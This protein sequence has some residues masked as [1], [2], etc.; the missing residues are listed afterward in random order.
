[1]PLPLRHSR[2]RFHL[3][4][5]G[6]VVLGDVAAGMI[7]GALGGAL[8]AQACTTGAPTCGGCPLTASCTYAA[9]FEPAPAPHLHAGFAD[10]PRPYVL[11]LERPLPAVVR[12]G[13]TFAFDLVLVES[14]SSALAAL[15]GAVRRLEATGL[16][17]ART[18]ERG[19]RS[20]RI[21]LASVEALHG[22]APEVVWRPG[23]RLPQ[24]GPA[25]AW[26]GGA[27]CPAAEALRL[28]FTSP[29]RLKVGG[30]PC[31]APSLVDL[32]RALARRVT[33]F[34]RLHG[35]FDDAL[36]QQLHAAIDL[37]RGLDVHEA[38]FTPAVRE[39]YS[40]RQGRRIPLEGVLGRLVVG[41]GWEPLWPLLDA[42]RLLHVG[43]NATHGLG[44]YRLEAA[45]LPASIPS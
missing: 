42:G 14:A 40:A 9:L 16:G 26:L 3:R 2:Y 7:R 5:E 23:R 4:A 34:A 24:P 27:P 1:M 15:V 8:R 30:R 21:R 45:A 33:A 36:Q 44:A 38:R 18:V 13:R 41:A 32:V 12:P 17:D 28:T 29:V 11:H 10:A 31:A 39:R 19:G 35:R 37:A 43:K 25:P 6:R 22:E 20:G